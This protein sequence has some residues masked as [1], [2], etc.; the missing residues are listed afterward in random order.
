MRAASLA[1]FPQQAR[2]FRLVRLTDG[3]VALQTWVVD[4]AGRAT[5]PGWRGL[6]GISRDLAYLDVQGGRP[7]HEAGG[8]LDRNATLFL[9]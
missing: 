3:R 1:D 6:A 8:R 2:M 9:P 7:L 5:A 4:H